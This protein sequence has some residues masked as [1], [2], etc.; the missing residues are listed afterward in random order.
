M[1]PLQS[2]DID[3][4]TGRSPYGEQVAKAILEWCIQDLALV[5]ICVSALAIM[6]SLLAR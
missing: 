4:P 3:R 5:Q 2:D 6:R 1:R